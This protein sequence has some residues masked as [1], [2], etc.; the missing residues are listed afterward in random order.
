MPAIDTL[1]CLRVSLSQCDLLKEPIDKQSRNKFCSEHNFKSWFETS[2]KNGT[3]V[4]QA[5]LPLVPPT[6]AV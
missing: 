6:I 1:S 3:N 4:E 2:A 5:R